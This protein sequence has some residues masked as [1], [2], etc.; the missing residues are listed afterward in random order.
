MSSTVCYARKSASVSDITGLWSDRL[1]RSAC[2]SLDLTCSQVK[3]GRAATVGNTNPAALHRPLWTR[4]WQQKGLSGGDATTPQYPSRF[5]HRSPRASA[6][7]SAAQL[8]TV[9][10][11]SLAQKAWPRGQVHARGSWAEARGLHSLF[12]HKVS[13]E[14]GPLFPFFPT[15]G[16]GAN[17][18][19]WCDWDGSWLMTKEPAPGGNLLDPLRE[20]K[21]ERV[22]WVGRVPLTCICYHMPN[23]QLGGSCTAAQLWNTPVCSPVWTQGVQLGALWWPRGVGWGRWEGGS[24]GSDMC[25][26]HGWFT[27]LYSRNQHN[28]V[29]QLYFNNKRTNVDLI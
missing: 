6:G 9:L 26:T 27:L 23:R 18:R 3:P 16:K 1:P 10:P 24:R 14:P 15:A 21:E 7:H 13:S 19:A 20:N 8:G 11:A 29:K 4:P 12:H 5:I 22:G 2:K 28:I 17:Q 25:N